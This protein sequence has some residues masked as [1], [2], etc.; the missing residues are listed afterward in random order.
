[1]FVFSIVVEKTKVRRV[2]FQCTVYKRVKYL[3]MCMKCCI[4]RIFLKFH[5]QMFMISKYF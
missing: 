5:L 2:A 3:I 1:M 4:S